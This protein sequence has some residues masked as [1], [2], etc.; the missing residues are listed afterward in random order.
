[1]FSKDQFICV[2]G[3]GEF[4][5]GYGRRGVQGPTGDWSMSVKLRSTPSWTLLSLFF[6]LMDG[7]IDVVF[8]PADSSIGWCWFDWSGQSRVLQ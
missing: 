3:R 2:L 7:D 6:W 8:N 4:I 1:M 5:L